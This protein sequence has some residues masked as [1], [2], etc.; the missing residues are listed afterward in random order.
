MLGAKP[1]GIGRYIWEL[2]KAL[3]KALPEAEF[4]LYGRAPTGLP[5]ISSRWHDRL[6]VSAAAKRLPN[7]LWGVLRVGF[8]TRRDNLSVFWGGTGL[9]PLVGLRARSV[10]TVYDFVY[11]LQPRTTSARARWAAR[12][13]FR[14]S[15]RRANSIVCISHGS[16][17]RLEG[18]LGRGSDAIIHPGV[19]EAFRKK[20]NAEVQS[21]LRGLLVPTPYLLA[22][23]TWEPRKGLQRLIPA[24]LSLADEGRLRSHVLVLSRRPWL[25]GR[26]D[27]SAGRRRRSTDSC[28]WVR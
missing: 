11:T 12:L 15:V 27:C 3:D 26:S 18:L 21:V 7:S 17:R 28:P 14:A 9:L 6:D 20:S 24:F 13:F 19:S 22:V 10:L 4:F 25:E 8:L 2:C 23:G 1:K 16:A 5:R